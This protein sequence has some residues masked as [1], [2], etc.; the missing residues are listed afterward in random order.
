VS[1]EVA[2]DLLLNVSD[3]DVGRGDEFQITGVDFTLESGDVMGLVGKSGAGKSTVMEAML[4]I[5]QNSGTVWL[6]KGDESLSVKQSAGYSTQEGSLYPLLTLD[7]NL[8]LFASLQGARGKEVDDRKK[9]LLRDLNLYEHRHRRVTDFSGGMKKRADLAASLVHDPLVLM[10]DE[11]LAG[12][13]P[14]QRRLIWQKI[15]SFVDAGKIVI[16]TSH[17]IDEMVTRCNKFGLVHDGSFFRA[18]Q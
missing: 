4:G 18:E 5:I 8:N 7:E 14:P 15:G 17:M 2:D 3:L 11:P 6:R 12:I 13:D 10:M 1:N 16:L 9:E